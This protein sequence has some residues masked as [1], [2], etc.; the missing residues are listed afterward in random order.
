MSFPLVGTHNNKRY[1]ACVVSSTYSLDFL[2]TD[3]RE[4]WIFL[5]IGHFPCLKRSESFVKMK[6]RFTTVDI[7]AVIAEINSK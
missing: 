7:K 5:F 4:M 3:V 6:T 1:C 2:A